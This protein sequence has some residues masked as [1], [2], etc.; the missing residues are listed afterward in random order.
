M[1]Q[2]GFEYEKNAADFLK[3]AELVDKS[4]VPAGAGHAQADLVVT[5]KGQKVNIE[6][7]ITAASGG[8]LVLKYDEK[9]PK[10]KK[11]AFNDTSNDPEKEFLAGVAEE[12]GALKIINKE[13]DDVPLKRENMSPEAKKRLPKD[14][15][16]QYEIDHANFPEINKI[17]SGR[18]I[19][20]YYNHKDTYYVNIGTS[21]FYLFGDKDPNGLN[22]NL[23]KAGMKLIPKFS[24][25]AKVKFRAR[26]QYKGSGSYQFVFELS[27]SVSGTSPYNIAPLGK[28]SVKILKEKA[29]ITCFP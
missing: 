17:I 24:D 2:Q 23:R 6:L 18:Y 16:K 26:V 14:K 4:F 28:G 8:S 11:W 7:K 5:Y 3:K 12:V 20:D 25:A 29:N 27:F 19:E 15:K 22:T 9:R 10:G 13:W 21:G 1:A